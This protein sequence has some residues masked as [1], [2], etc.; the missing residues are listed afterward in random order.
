L[1]EIA[2]LD[3]EPS[4]PLDAFRTTQRFRIDPKGSVFCG[5]PPTEAGVPRGFSAEQKAV[6][7]AAAQRS[8]T[9]YPPMSAPLPWPAIL[10]PPVSSTGLAERLGAGGLGGRTDRSVARTGKASRKKRESKLSIRLF[11]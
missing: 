1:R 5:R 2:S 10:G 7:V 4:S 9:N 6:L 8:V 3:D 11:F